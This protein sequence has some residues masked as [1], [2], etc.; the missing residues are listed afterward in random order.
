M[1]TLTIFWVALMVVL[2]IIEIY[3][4][5]LTTVWFA[6]GACAAAFVSVLFPDILPLQILVFA[7]VSAVLLPL[8]RPFVKKIQK[9]IVRTNADRNVGEEALV[10]EKVD[11]RA[12]SGQV[13]VLGQI[14]T[15]RSMLPERIY[16]AGE[17]VTVEKIDGVKLIVRDCLKGANSS[18]LTIADGGNKNAEFS[19]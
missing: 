17:F 5:N 18:A 4:F 9:N 19:N 12:S 1:G 11:N 15:A 14:W 2:V 7:A 6:L 16:E 8:T 3:T 13:K 10:I